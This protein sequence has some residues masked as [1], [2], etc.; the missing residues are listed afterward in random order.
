[1]RPAQWKAIA[2]LILTWAQDDGTSDELM[3]IVDPTGASPVDQSFWDEFETRLRA[4]AA[5]RK[6]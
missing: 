3:A 1:M 6:R 4:F 5:P 2:E